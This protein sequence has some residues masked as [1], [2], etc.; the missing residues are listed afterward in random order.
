MAFFDEGFGRFKNKLFFGSFGKST[1]SI[2][3][4]LFLPFL[5]ALLLRNLEF[6]DSEVTYFPPFAP[7]PNNYM[8]ALLSLSID[9]DQLLLRPSTPE[10]KKI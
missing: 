6:R 1:F 10:E 8:Y 5:S 3:S 9:P 2:F 4:L 7:P